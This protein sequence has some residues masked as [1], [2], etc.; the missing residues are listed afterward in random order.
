MINV[1]VKNYTPLIYTFIEKF[2]KLCDM[3]FL[4][5]EVHFIFV[6]KSSDSYIPYA[7]YYIDYYFILRI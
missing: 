5:Y 1:R 2:N 4:C 6:D 7:L 3:L